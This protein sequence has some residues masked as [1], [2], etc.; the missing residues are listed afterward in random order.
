[1]DT[2][3]L[4]VIFHVIARSTTSGRASRVISHSY[5]NEPLEE[6]NWV[7]RTQFNKHHYK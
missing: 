5:V 1:M 7:A 2:A 6:T 4:L 3:K